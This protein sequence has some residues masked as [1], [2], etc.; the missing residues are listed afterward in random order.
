[1]SKRPVSTEIGERFMPTLMLTLVSMVWSTLLGM[2][3][4]IASAVWRN[5]WPDRLGMTI[6]V[7]GISFP[8]FA[9]G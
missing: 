1:R 6:A 4:G 2:A 5:R 7:S 9:L 3:I 8:A